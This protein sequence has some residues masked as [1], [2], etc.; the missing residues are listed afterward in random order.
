MTHKALN[1]Y[2]LAISRMKL[3]DLQ[4]ASLSLPLTQ[5]GLAISFNLLDAMEAT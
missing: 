1:I 5:A 4:V 2:Y 3:A